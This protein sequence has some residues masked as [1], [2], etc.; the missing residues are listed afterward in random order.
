MGNSSASAKSINVESRM[1]IGN[2]SMSSS[3]KTTKVIAPVDNA[4]IA[5]KFLG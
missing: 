2:V 4:A 3:G 5:A 1:F